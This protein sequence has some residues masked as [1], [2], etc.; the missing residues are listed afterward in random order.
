[1]NIISPTS[2]D[3]R[4]D[5]RICILT[6]ADTLSWTQHYVDAF[7]QRA[8]VITVGRRPG[9]L[10]TLLGD[11]HPGGDHGTVQSGDGL[12]LA[13]IPLEVLRHAMISEDGR[14]QIDDAP[15]KCWLVKD[16]RRID[17]TSGRQPDSLPPE[18]HKSRAIVE[19]MRDEEEEH[20]ESAIHAGAAE[21]PEPIKRLMTLTAR[22]MTET[23]YRV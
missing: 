4:V 21:L 6:S 23:A 3:S 16:V 1:M 17:I 13:S 11:A 22:I 20:G 18:D 12:F 5:L 7:R 15:T 14:L 2:N 9:P 19:Q 8:N 10:A